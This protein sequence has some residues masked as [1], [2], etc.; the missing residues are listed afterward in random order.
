MYA[1]GTG[2]PQDDAE[3]VKWF[4]LAAEQGHVD[5]Q[6][7]LGVMYD[8]GEGVSQNEADGSVQ[9][10]WDDPHCNVLWEAIA[11]FA[12]QIEQTRA[13]VDVRQAMNNVNAA[14]QAPFRAISRLKFENPGL[15]ERLHSNPAMKDLAGEIES[16]MHAIQYV[17]THE[18][19]HRALLD[20]T[21][22]GM[23]MFRLSYTVACGER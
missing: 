7:N 22:A 2:V 4:S 1:N 20:M 18:E 11:E 14:I 10:G 13:A 16:A 17:G 6:N 15:E 19:L 3:A 21:D 9:A 23:R 12:F 8:N 5:A